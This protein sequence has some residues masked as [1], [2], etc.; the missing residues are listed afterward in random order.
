MSDQ[1]PRHRNQPERL[2]LP[3]I[4]KSAPAKKNPPNPKSRPFK[5][6]LDRMRADAQNQMFAQLEYDRKSRIKKIE[7]LRSSKVLVYYSALPLVS[8]DFETI[9]DCVSSLGKQDNLDLYV[10]SRGGLINP[11]YKIARLFQDYSNSKFSVLIP[12]FAKSAAT[13]L[14]LGADEVVMGPASELGPID[15]QISLE[16]SSSL[17]PVLALKESLEYIKKEIQNNQKL[18][19][20]YVPLMDKVDLIT[21]GHFEREIESAKQYGAELLTLRKKN[22]LGE[23]QAAV[24]AEKLVEK[25]KTHDFVIDGKAASS[26]L[27]G[28]VALLDSSDPVWQCMWQ[29]HYIYEQSIKEGKII[30][31][32]ETLDEAYLTRGRNE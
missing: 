5:V 11:A 2:A 26:L 20:L 13:I 19:P 29:M 25:Y 6:R 32:I 23:R 17:T 10:F 4:S 14:S 22:K 1:K 21:L 24:I 27:E 28:A 30:K 16:N 9:F 15:P 7:E 12:Y 18:A 31:I 3:K 8:K